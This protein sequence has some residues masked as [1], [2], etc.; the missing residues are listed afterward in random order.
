MGLKNYSFDSLPI[1]LRAGGTASTSGSGNSPENGCEEYTHGF[2]PGQWHNESAA[3][4]L[5]EACIESRRMIMMIDT[6]S[7]LQLGNICDI[8][9]VKNGLLNF[10]PM[11]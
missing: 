6:I 4:I 3:I 2:I 8:P 5:Y 10:E 11:L 7:N 1:C 9:D